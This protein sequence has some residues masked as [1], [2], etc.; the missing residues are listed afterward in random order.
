[1]LLAINPMILPG[2]EAMGT[3]STIESRLEAVE[4]AIAELKRKLEAQPSAPNWL[5]HVIGI[6]KDESE[7]DEVIRLGRE[8]RMAGRFTEDGGL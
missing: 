7:F 8:F 5:D 2:E 1:L 3:N 4:D 6:F